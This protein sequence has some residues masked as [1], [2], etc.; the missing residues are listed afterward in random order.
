M[1]R[2]MLVD[3]E[4]WTLRDLEVLLAD[5]Q[6]YEIVGSF[7]DSVKAEQAL[8]QLKPDVLLTD[9]KMN[10]RSGRDLINT[11]FDNKLKTRSVIISAYSDF[12]TARD[13]LSKGVFD[14]LLKPIK[15]TDL[16]RVFERLNR[17]FEQEQGKNTAESIHTV[18][19]HAAAY[20]KCCCAT[21]RKMDAAAC[22]ALLKEQLGEPCRITVAKEEETLLVSYAGSGLSRMWME[23]Q[24]GKLGFSRT[25]LGFSTYDSMVKEARVALDAAFVY[26][27]HAQTAELQAYLALHYNQDIS[28][29]QLAKY[30]HLSMNYLSVLFTKNAGI[31]CMGFLKHLRVAAAAHLLETTDLSMLQ[32][33]EAVGYKDDSYFS[34]VFKAKQGM[35]P[36]A[37]RQNNNRVG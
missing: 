4:I 30:F 3:D 27:D 1:L 24:Q 14:Y 21:Y 9:L 28:L 18:L 11:A 35:S 25:M 20:E 13:G 26:A 15:K 34:R 5:F 8:L 2:I 23:N 17:F 16:Q 10:I 33:A 36:S 31:S 19:E 6:G 12:E 7:T 32:I 29:E 37:Y 22:S